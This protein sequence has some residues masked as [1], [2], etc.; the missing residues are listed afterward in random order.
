VLGT[1]Q[2]GIVKLKVADWQQHHDLIGNIPPIAEQLLKTQPDLAPQLI[3]R[4]V[5]HSPF[6]EIY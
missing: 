4:W 2:T 6:G 5:Y 1:R 3:R